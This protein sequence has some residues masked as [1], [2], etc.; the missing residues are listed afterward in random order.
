VSHRG[1]DIEDR[2]PDK[3][4][5]G[6]RDLPATSHVTSQ[7]QPPALVMTTGTKSDLE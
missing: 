7:V 1:V 2:M 3:E 4:F 6:E 5:L